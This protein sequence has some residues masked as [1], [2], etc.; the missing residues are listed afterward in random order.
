MS[1]EVVKE[2]A[3]AWVA[4]TSTTISIN[5]KI[6]THKHL[7]ANTVIVS[8]NN[9]SSSTIYGMIIPEDHAAEPTGTIL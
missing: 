5:I 2:A 8:F 1:R 4:N 6:R 3:R 7:V 9:N